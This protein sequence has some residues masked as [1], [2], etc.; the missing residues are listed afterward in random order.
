MVV[1]YLEYVAR[2]ESNA[3]LCTRDA[4]VA[5]GFVIELS[6]HVNL[7]ETNESRTPK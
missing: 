6:P 1:K 7:F 2:L 3:G 5:E 4:V